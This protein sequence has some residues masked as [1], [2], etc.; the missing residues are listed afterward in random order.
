MILGMIVLAALGFALAP[1]ALAA[2]LI[3]W[4]FSGL[5]HLAGL[6]ILWLLGAPLWVVAALLFGYH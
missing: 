3:F 1:L 2:V 5:I 4:M 6:L